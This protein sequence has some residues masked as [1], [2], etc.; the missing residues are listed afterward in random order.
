MRASKP[1]YPAEFTRAMI[2][3]RWKIPRIFHL[4]GGAKRF[5]ELFRTLS[6]VTQKVLTQQLRKME[7]HRLVERRVYAQVPPKVDYS[8]TTLGQSLKS[9]VDVMCRGGEL[10]GASAV[11]RAVQS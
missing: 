6:G 9:V 4:L 11:L 1:K 7:R 3:G 10:H 8:P 5:S 2:G